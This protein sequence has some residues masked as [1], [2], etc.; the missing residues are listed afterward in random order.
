MFGRIDD[1]KFQSGAA[2]VRNF[3]V[4]PTGAAKN[5]AGFAYVNATKNNGVARLIPFTFSLNQ[6]MVIE[7][8]DQYA[9]FHT[10]GETMKCDFTGVP[11]WI[12]PSGDISISYTTPAIVTWAGH[13][14]ATGAPI[15]FYLYGAHS[16]AEL[17]AGIQA[18]Y[19]YTVQVIDANNFNILDNGVPVGLV[20][21]GSLG[22]GTTYNGSGTATT[23]IDC[24][25]FQNLSSTSGTLSGLAS[26][27]VPGGQ[28]TL[29]ATI[30]STVY[31]DQGNATA[32]IS[33]QYSTG[34]GWNTFHQTSASE[35]TSVSIQIPITN[36][37][38]LQLRIQVS[39][40]SNF[41]GLN[42]SGTISAWSIVVPTTS[43]G[44]SL[45]ILRAYRYYTAGDLTIYSG[46]KYLEMKADTG[47]TTTPGTDSSVWYPAPADLSYEITTPYLAADLFDIHFIQSADV[48]TLVHQNYPPQELKR[49]S[50]KGWTM[51]PSEFGYP[52]DTPQNP[53]VVASPGYLA[54]IASISTADP[55]LIT[56]TTNHTLALGDG[57][58]LAGL[59]SATGFYLVAKVPKDS[60]GNLIQNELYLMDYS[61]N[62]FVYVGYVSGATLQYG[63]KIYD[64]TNYYAVQAV[65][66]DGVS[67]GELSATVSVLNNLNVPGS[68]N[69]I[70]WQA[71]NGTDIYYYIYKKK[72]GLWGL[73]GSTQALSFVDNNI[74]AD[75]SITPG[76]PYG[77]FSKAGDYPGAAGYFQQRK[78][79]GG[80]LNAPQNAWMSNSGTEGM[81]DYS[82]PS[83]DTDA[84]VFRVAAQK[85][86]AIVHII[87]MKQLILLTSESEF[88]LESSG[89]SAI[90]PSSVSVSPQSYIGASNVQPT[91]INTTTVYVAARGG[92]VRELGYAWT[93]NGYM[94]ND[95]SL[96]AA[97]LFDNLTIV[98]QAYSKSPWPIVWFVSSS[99]DLLGFTYIPEEQ[100]GAWH[101]HDTHGKF[102]S[103]VSVSE[104]SEDVLYAVINRTING[105]TVR[106]IERQ[107]SRVIDPNDS[108]TWF[109]VD[110]GISQSFEEPVTRISGLTWLEGCTVAVLADGGVQSQKVVTGGAITL[111]HAASVVQI[112]L[113]YTSDLL[114][115]PAVMQVDG[116]GQGRTKNVNK[117]WV[118]VYQSSG[119]FVGPDEDHLTEIRQ[120]TNEPWG[121]P[122]ALQS[123]EL[124]VMTSPYW[125]AGG[126]TLIRQKNPLPLEVVGLTLEVAIGG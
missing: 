72:N 36:I 109:F 27:V 89:S 65:A 15:R 1:A 24:T 48:M 67:A 56:T 10:N 102:E 98:D 122:P 121:S 103:C 117:A 45:T 76:T 43:G 74:A 50:A 88:V 118:K 87:P 21:P 5:R 63:T 120:R 90:T 47:G 8:G 12:P 86:D 39:G 125:Q 96:R 2:K 40:K 69:T 70:S 19:T 58:Y 38:L 77:V 22:T 81:F 35:S 85:A 18:G 83:L 82:L 59:G 57:V 64:I 23:S 17:P 51:T 26:V 115:L 112:G 73:I 99:G 9:R 71:V 123:A 108:S 94:T 78:C 124:E 52:L 110:A 3:V 31:R 6:T 60:D 113:P 93:Q 126:Q 61:G 54:Q 14:L 92:H 42:A 20:N 66:S 49:L 4:T 16:S 11:A 106:Y 91:I 104:G 100:M 75:M 101:H 41:F 84:V 68:Y 55:A 7:L 13:G 29:N 80:T 44:S 114:T 37:N 34:S 107:A 32:T 79:F 33:Y 105:A 25:P 62:P 95:L 116:Y 30:L 46:N 111:D 53:A 97:H 28:A 119:I